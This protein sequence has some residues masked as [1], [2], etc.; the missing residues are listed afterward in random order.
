M[1]TL[2]SRA[3]R[4]PGTCRC[5]SCISNSSA[6][7]RQRRTILFQGSWAFGTLT[8]TFVYTVI[9]AAGIAMDGSAKIKRNEQWRAA[10]SLL[11]KKIELPI[12]S[13]AR[14]PNGPK[15]A[16]KEHVLA[17]D[18]SH[19][20][21]TRYIPL[22]EVWPEGIKWEFLHRTIGMDIV[23][24]TVRETGYDNAD[25]DSIGEGLEELLAH[26][27]RLPGRQTLEWP[28]NTGWNLVRENLYPQSLW[29]TDHAR[30]KALRRRHTWKKLASQELGIGMLIHDLLSL[31]DFAR[32]PEKSWNELSKPILKIVRLGPNAIQALR[33]EIKNDLRRIRELPIDL[34]IEVITEAKRYAS[35]YKTMLPSYHQDDDGEF[36]LTTE[37]MNAAIGRLLFEKKIP[38]E[39]SNSAI[40]IAKVCHN[41]LVSSA[42]PDVQTFNM[43]IS[44][45]KRL[46]YDD[47]VDKVIVAFYVCHIRP[48]E[49]TCAAILDHFIRQNKSKNFSHFVA[50]M[51]GAGQ[52][53]MLANPLWPTGADKERR[54]ERVSDYKI[55]Q[56]IYPSPIVFNTLMLGALKFAGFE[57]AL[58]IYYEM[59]E[60]GWGLDVLGLVDF[61]A[62]CVH[63]ADWNGGLYIWEEI[64]TIKARAKRN[65][66][67]RAYA[68]ML[69]LCA[70][71]QNTP[72]FNH[73]LIEVV[74]R[75]V[76]GR[77][78]LNSAMRMTQ[79]AQQTEHFNA[80]AWTADN[81]MT[82]LSIL[83]GSDNGPVIEREPAREP[84]VDSENKFK[85]Q[86][87]EEIETERRWPRSQVDDQSSTLVDS[88]WAD[89]WDTT[90][91]K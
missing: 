88:E 57:R 71:T 51:R 24:N 39:H 22:E 6:I 19:V 34:P 72:A 33:E 80:P 40:L 70:V 75:K 25:F 29:S 16:I 52:G 7:Y 74:D 11:Q 41:L 1:L 13:E 36:Y 5:L 4:N 66:L 42:G 68:T 62:D 32:L 50:K 26:D 61:L 53:L 87:M 59:K 37:Q 27:S 76:D 45:F 47:M 17:E 49:I 18:E 43:L 10:L 67:A 48:N 20:F 54:L 21:G 14:Q 89:D 73:I 9:F 55:V 35:S 15:D 58:D 56:A 38:R 86:M 84:G 79:R 78:I 81:V 85:Q 91:P 12:E 77:E 64:N 82:A 46:N 69:S 63:R 3:A 30:A 23:D 65:H 60:D 8:S 83:E 31:A 2:W 44:G 90:A 28:V